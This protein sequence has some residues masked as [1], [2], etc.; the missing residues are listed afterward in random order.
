MQFPGNEHKNEYKTVEFLRKCG[1]P[2][3]CGTA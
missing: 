1:A 2:S 3:D